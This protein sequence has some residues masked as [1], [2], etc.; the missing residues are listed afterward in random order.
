MV[1]RKRHAKFQ[2]ISMPKKIIKKLN[3]VYML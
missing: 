1:T 2:E 3:I